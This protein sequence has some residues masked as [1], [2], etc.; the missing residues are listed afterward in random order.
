MSYRIGITPNRRAATR[1]V[2]Q[3]VR[4]IQKAFADTPDVSQAEVARRLGVDRSLIN[5]Q[6]RGSQDMSLGRVAEIA[7]AL[8]YSL[9]LV[10]EKIDSRDLGNMPPMPTPAPPQP[11]GFK[12]IEIKASSGAPQTVEEKSK[13]FA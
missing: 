12:V 8:G 6:L 3:V 2:G 4:S 10:L 13:E 7:W 11:T 1:F 9:G 5:R